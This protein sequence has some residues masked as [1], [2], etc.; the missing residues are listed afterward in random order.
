MGFGVLRP[1]LVLYGGTRRD[2][3]GLGGAR[4]AGLGAILQDMAWNIRAALGAVGQGRHGGAGSSEAG[5]DTAGLGRV[6]HGPA[7]RGEVG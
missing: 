7:G 4:Q 1:G 2:L 5:F 6:R 3:V